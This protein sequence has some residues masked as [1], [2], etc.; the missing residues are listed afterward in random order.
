MAEEQSAQSGALTTPTR[1]ALDLW[2]KE[3]VHHLEVEGIEVDVDAI[4]GISDQADE[5]VI[6]PA[7]PVTSFLIGYVSGVAEATGQ[8]DFATCHRAAT[9]VAERLLRRR[10][11]AVG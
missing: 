9:R 8:A 10:Q 4:V 11:N 1:E 5:T 6:D 3:L 7:G 2:V